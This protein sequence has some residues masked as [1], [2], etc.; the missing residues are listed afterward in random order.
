MKFKSKATE[1]KVYKSAEILILR[2]GT[3]GW[4]MNDLADAAGI[5]KGTLYKIIT[6]KEQLIHDVSFRNIKIM[7]EKILEVTR[8]EAAFM[9]RIERLA[10]VVPGLLKNNYINTYSDILKELPGLEADIV[11]ENELIFNDMVNFFQ[12]GIDEGFLRKDISPQLIHHMVQAI[13]L[14][15][16]KYSIPGGDFTEKMKMALHCLINGIVIKN[17]ESS[18]ESD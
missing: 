10:V 15:F 17:N 2:H 4:N 7:R 5:T 14:Y 3:R 18:A 1:E 8:S 12:S 13:I 11:R 16:A 9:E 6:S